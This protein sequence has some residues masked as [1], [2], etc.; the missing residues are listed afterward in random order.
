MNIYDYIDNNLNLK[1]E[2]NEYISRISSQYSFLPKQQKKLAKYIL[3][4]QDEV[5]HSSI[6]TLLLWFQRDEVSYV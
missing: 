2:A 3:S 1:D 4:H 6:T 5:I